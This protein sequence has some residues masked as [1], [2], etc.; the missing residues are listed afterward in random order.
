MQAE[1]SEPADEVQWECGAYKR[2]TGLRY[3]FCVFGQLK[4]YAIL[5]GPCE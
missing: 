1:M 3:V 4:I 2:F 5:W